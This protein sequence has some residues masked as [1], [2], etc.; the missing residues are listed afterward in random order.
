MSS[1]NN[2]NSKKIYVTS[3]GLKKLEQELA[4]LIE[5]KRPE[6]AERIAQ[7]KEF[8]DIS[9]NCEYE[10]AKEEQAFVEGRISQLQAMLKH[11]VIIDEKSKHSLVE[12]GST[13]KVKVEDGQEQF[14]IVGSAEANPFDGKISH[15]SPIGKALLGRKVGESVKV[16]IPAGFIE[17]KILSIH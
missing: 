10:A 15:E 17:M 11:A 4:E 14:T 16:Q 1:T 5:T 13:I 9:E 12:V 3:E 6:V 2:N 7:A 8:G